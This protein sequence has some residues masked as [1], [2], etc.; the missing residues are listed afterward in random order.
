MTNLPPHNLSIALVC[1]QIAPNT[2]N[3]A[4]LCVATGTELHLVRPLGFLLSDRQLKRS[5]MDYWARLKLTVH[6]DVE[7]FLTVAA[8]RRVWLCENGS[9]RSVW[10]ADF[11]DYDLL[12]LGNEGAGL[13][14]VIRERFADRLIGI[15]QA[16]GERCLNLS[17]AA[18]IALAE[19]LR[20]VTA[21]IK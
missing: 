6:D 8:N 21:L 13:P 10:D 14:P 16:P 17:T 11:R 20:Q 7:S 9:D 18:G 12:V 1:P 2:G 4:R 19:A 5:A 15:P 3:I